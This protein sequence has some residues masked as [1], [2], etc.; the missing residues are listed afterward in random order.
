MTHQEFAQHQEKL[1][2]RLRELGTT[3][4][5]EY[6]GDQDRFNNFNSLAAELEMPREKVLWV[7][8]AKHLRSIQ[9]WLRKGFVLSNESIEGRLEGAILYLVLLHGMVAERRP[10]ARQNPKPEC[11]K[12]EGVAE[13]N[14]ANSGGRWL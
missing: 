1:F 11:P 5:V 3:K 10:K 2:E 14:E 9:S 13:L 8:L 7:Y 4:G 12:P 6:A